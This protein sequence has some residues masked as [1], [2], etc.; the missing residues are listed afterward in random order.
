MAAN[1]QPEN[2]TT[3]TAV[4][5][6]KLFA[7]YYCIHPPT[8]SVRAK[9][10]A[11]DTVRIVLIVLAVAVTFYCCYFV[12]ERSGMRK[13]SVLR[14]LLDTSMAGRN[15]KMLELCVRTGGFR[16]NLEVRE[17]E[18][19]RRGNVELRRWVGRAV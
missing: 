2:A 3:A 14:E 15:E 18:R 13:T 17:F 19:R 12:G 4:T 9:D 8:T 1:T 6:C 10:A 16:G 7:Q 11:L 5:T